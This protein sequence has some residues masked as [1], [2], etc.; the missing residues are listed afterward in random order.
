MISAENLTILIEQIPAKVNPELVV[1]LMAIGALIKH[2]KKF[3]KVQNKLI[4][5]IL[6]VVSLTISFVCVETWTIDSVISTI[7]SGV[8]NA[9][10]AVYLHQTGKSIFFKKNNKVEDTITPDTNDT[11]SS[12]VIGS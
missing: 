5:V 2:C 8:V 10:A 12:M 6:G 7:A 3:E 11:G 9:G 4:P 1:L